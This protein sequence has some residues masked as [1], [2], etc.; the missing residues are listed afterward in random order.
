MIRAESVP[1]R[2]RPVLETAAIRIAA[3]VPEAR[4][5]ID[6]RAHRTLRAAMDRVAVA[7]RITVA[8]ARPHAMAMAVA[9][10]NARPCRIAIAGVRTVAVTQM[11]RAGAMMPAIAG[12]RRAAPG[13]ATIAIV[14]DRIGIGATGVAVMTMP[15]DNGALPIVRARRKLAGLRR[16]RDRGGVIRLT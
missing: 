6:M 15:T 5:M 16:A 11:R 7:R 1:V 13:N 10:A 2:A 3:A 14:V 9:V 12:D 4:R 8:N